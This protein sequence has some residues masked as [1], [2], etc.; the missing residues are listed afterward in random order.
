MITTFL[1]RIGDIED[2]VHSSLRSPN[3]GLGIMIMHD[4]KMMFAFE[5]RLSAVE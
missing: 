5:N 2:S 4:L 3:I 1:V